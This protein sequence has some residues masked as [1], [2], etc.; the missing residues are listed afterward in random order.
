MGNLEKNF[1][2]LESETSELWNEKIGRSKP[3][4]VGKQKLSAVLA[5]S[6]GQ[7]VELQGDSQPRP[8]GLWP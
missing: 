1:L 2:L 5:P 7:D 8:L 4:G 3:G 6:A